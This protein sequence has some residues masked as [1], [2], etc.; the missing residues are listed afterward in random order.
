MSLA[1]AKR[2]KARA[3]RALEDVFR[4]LFEEIDTDKIRREVQDLRASDEFEAEH[5]ARALIRRTAIRCAAAGAVTGLPSGLLAIGTLGADLAYLMYQ[6]FRL[7]V[8]IATIYGHEP[9]GRER[10][11]EALSCLA[12]SSG[13]GIGKQG[14]ASVL[15]SATVEGGVV[16][17]RLGMR[18]A[19]E[20]LTRV[21]PFVGVVSG[22]VLNYVAVRAVGRTAI[23]FYEGRVAKN[24]ADAIWA[25][26]DR[27]HA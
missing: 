24:L 11:T 4:G 9:S 13:V 18:F 1:V 15:E 3:D 14:L 25:D 8:G 6:Q 2:F 16:A 26:G 23:R 27:E 7:I 21:V 20:R 17:D 10:F 22:G 12:Y 19:R 5:H